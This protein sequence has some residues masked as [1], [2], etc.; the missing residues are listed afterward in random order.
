MELLQWLELAQLLFEINFFGGRK[1]HLV[2]VKIC[3]RMC[4][5]LIRRE[6][7]L[8]SDDLG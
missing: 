3:I 5:L 1:L 8:I 4:I 2:N 7:A 6:F